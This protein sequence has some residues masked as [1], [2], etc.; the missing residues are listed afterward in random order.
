[1]GFYEFQESDARLFAQ[2]TGVS[3]RERGDQLQFK[4]CPYCHGG[5]SRDKWT[6]AISLTDGGFNCQR[7]SC[8]V[9]GGMLKLSED[10]DFSLGRDNDAYYKRDKKF[11]DLSKYPRPQTK[12][13]AVRYMLTRGISEEITR[14]YNLT[15]Q[16]DNDGILVFPFIDPDGKM[17]F[18]KYRNTQHVEGKGSKEWCEA[19]C[20]PIL[21]GMNHCNLA[22]G[23]LIL[24]EGQIDSLTLNECGYNNAVSVPTGK[25][26]FTWY[27]YCYDWL[28]QFDTLIVFGDCEHGEI[29]LLK[30][31]AERFD[32]IVK[33]VRPEDYRECKDANELFRTYG[34][35]AVRLAVESAVRVENPK[36]VDLFEIR[37]QN[38]DGMEKF[39]TG[40]AELDKVLGGF[41]LGQFV[42]IT[43]E[44]G[45]GKSTLASQLVTRGM[46]VGYPA[47]IYSGEL[48]DWMVQ[49]WILRQLAGRKNIIG[50][51]SENGF[52]T[53]SVS[54]SVFQKIS[55]KYSG[56]IYNYDNGLIDNGNELDAQEPLLETIE[57]A[58][59]QY[60]CRVILIDNLMTAIEDDLT[61]DVYRLQSN[62]AKKLAVMA[63][64]FNVLILLVAH[65]RKQQR[66]SNFG[67]DDVAGSANITNLVDVVVKYSRAAEHEEHDSV[68]NVYKNR[69]TGKFTPKEGIPLYFEESSKRISDTAGEFD[70][71]TGWESMSDEP[72]SEQYLPF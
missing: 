70:W 29:T 38:L 16:K 40:I 2:R 35:D 28:K 4:E 19:N 5:K 41:Y 42:V 22:D 72:E 13:P 3:T 54:N 25:N 15:C 26:G 45:Q 37:R 20:R 50:N 14:R 32:G 69:L 11:R 65:P 57:T 18:V 52:T 51:R 36:I 34:A 71:Q 66:G 7:A 12:D 53:Y 55:G 68:L 30:E 59:K 60:G 48:N 56:M 27:P 63:K 17:Q 6:F 43:G 33:H 9:R 49:D 39:S 23:R 47:L 64:R 8:G 46:T 62:F 24:T 10:F 31:M 21:F 58:I 61:S 1:M 44:R 67:N